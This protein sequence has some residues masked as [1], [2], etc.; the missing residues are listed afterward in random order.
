MGPFVIP[1]LVKLALGA[2]GAAA[3]VAW[4]VKEVRRVNEELDAARRVKV[5]ERVRPG[6]M[7]TLRRDPNTGEYRPM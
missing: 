3:V 7:P 6:S 2:V 1:P 5:T 4:V